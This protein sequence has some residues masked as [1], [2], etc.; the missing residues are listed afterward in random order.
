L[1]VREQ[2]H[3][4]SHA[5]HAAQTEAHEL[6]ELVAHSK[7]IA[8][9]YIP[10]RA[11]YTRKLGEVRALEG[12]LQMLLE[13]ANAPPATRPPGGAPAGSRD[14]ARAASHPGGRYERRDG[15]GG[16]Q[17]ARAEA[18]AAAAAA[19]A[20]EAE[21]LRRLNYEAEAVEEDEASP[22]CGLVEG[23]DD[24]VRHK[25]RSNCGPCH[26][27]ETRNRR[28]NCGPCHSRETCRC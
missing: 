10:P 8:G 1:Q 13:A 24:E 22:V 16:A 9:F 25:R 12:R 11:V 20:E 14:G 21:R 5:I 15:E 6:S 3:E 19:A 23:E 17:R 4:L 7:A 18:A 27:R 26:S 28:S 2:V